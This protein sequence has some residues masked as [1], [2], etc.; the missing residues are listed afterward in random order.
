MAT[1]ER[2]QVHELDWSVAVL[3]IGAGACGL[4]TALAA[5]DAGAEVLVLEQDARPSGSTGMSYGAICA[6]ATGLQQAEGINDEGQWL[7]EDIM[8]VTRGQT[9]ERL[10]RT[11]AE[12]CGP[13]VDWLVAR[14]GLELTVVTAW[15][16]LGH[17]QPRLHAPHSR[18]G[19]HLMGMLLQAVQKAGIDVLTEARVTTLLVD[20]DDRV[21]GVRIQ[22]PD[23]SLETL[24]CDTL[25]LATCGFGDNHEWVA[26]HIPELAD[27]RYYGHEGNRGDGIAWG[28]ELGAACADMGSFQALGSLAHPQSLVIPHTLLIGGGVQVNQLGLRFEDELDD[29]SGQ[30]LTILEQPDALCWMVYDQRLH[31]Q[32]LEGF[33]EYRDAVE[34]NTPK[35]AGDWAGL[36]AATGMAP[37]TFV[38][39]MQA[40]QKLAETAATDEFGR[41][42]R[43]G[44]KLIPPFYATRVTGALFHTQ[45]GLVVNEQARVLR[46]DGSAL[47]NL[48]AGGG[49]ACSVSG[50]GGWAYLP[51]MGLCTAVTLGRLAGRAAADQALAEGQRL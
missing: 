24:G 8:A 44:Q 41:S 21:C 43:P 37:E 48:W 25:V 3:V 30:A 20:N 19:E 34:M 22:R 12:N 27:A 50:P 23:G 49:A 46:E 16:G 13:A 4:T 29:I 31:E 32:A 38:A 7:F 36:A 51:G 15:T 17:R 9:S 11:L 33:Q 5:S 2:A 26:K 1:I 10:A 6:A 14:H 47:P 39:T 35:R 18:S 28:R 45:G 40:V 42:F